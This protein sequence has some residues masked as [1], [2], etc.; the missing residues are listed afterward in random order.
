MTELIIGQRVE[1]EE[2]TQTYS[3]YREFIQCF[4]N[5][6]ISRWAERCLPTKGDILIVIG[7][8][9][10]LKTSAMLYI[11][12]DGSGRIYIM[13]NNHNALIVVDTVTP[14]AFYKEI[15]IDE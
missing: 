4:D 9:K 1:V 10:H 12:E 7:K 5:E 3:T 15:G 13:G 14:D 8:K 6:F 11:V 2:P